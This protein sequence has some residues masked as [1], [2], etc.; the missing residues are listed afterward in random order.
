M[1]QEWREMLFKLFSQM[2]PD[3]VKCEN[4]DLILSLHDKEDREYFK[5]LESMLI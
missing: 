1:T 2:Y 5:M 3:G 4:Y